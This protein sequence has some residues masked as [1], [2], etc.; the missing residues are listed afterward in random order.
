MRKTTPGIYLVI[1]EGAKVA[2]PYE[3]VDII[4]EGV[5]VLENSNNVANAC[6]MMLGL[7]YTYMSLDYPKI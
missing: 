1:H 3:D 4:N 5:Q 7:T 2:D 6:I